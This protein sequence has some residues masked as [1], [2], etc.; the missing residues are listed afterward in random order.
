MKD[1]L[2]LQKTMKQ[3]ADKLLVR[4]G[5]AESREKAQAL[6]MAGLVWVGERRVKKPGELLKEDVELKVKE[7]LPYVS[8]GGIKLE[9]AL[10]EFKI[11]VKGKIAADFGASTGGF[12]DCLLKKGAKR[13]YAIDVGYGQMHWRLRSDPRVVL[14]EKVNVRYIDSS[15]IKDNI[16]LVVAD[17]S[18]ISLKLVLPKIME[19]L[20]P[21]GE[22]LVLVKPQFEVGRDK[23]GKRGVVRDEKLIFQAVEDIKIFAQD[24]GFSIKGV[25]ESPIRGAKGNREF[26]IYLSKKPL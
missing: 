1:G 13:V 25:C 17:L 2:L 19:I 16:D 3:R 22:A 23:V 15:L 7:P 5:L 8:R 10:D 14:L 21:D 24:I 4:K 12:T 9:K 26:F 11:E 18:F 20:I 6:I